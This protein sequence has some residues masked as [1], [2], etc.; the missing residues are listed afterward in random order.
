MA[1]ETNST[2]LSELELAKR[3]AKDFK[4]LATLIKPSVVVIESV[5]RNGYEGGRGTGFVV[6]EDG[7]I[8]TNFHVIGEHRDFSIRLSDGRTFRPHSILAID[9][10]RDLA[11]IKIEAKALPVLQLGDSQDLIP[12]QAVLSIGNPLGYE[13][14]VSRGVIAAVRELEFGDGRPMVQVAITIEPGS[15]G[16][17]ALDLNGNVIAILSIKSGG[18]MGFGV[19]VNELKGFLAS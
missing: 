12:G 4:N 11:L 13:H 5:D 8:A 9:R 14:S 18:A 3:D 10:D 17:P 6:R 1:E 2:S 15:S 16:S 19:P 7:V